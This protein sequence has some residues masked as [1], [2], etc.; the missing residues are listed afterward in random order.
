MKQSITLIVPFYNAQQTILLCL[1]SIF[2][3]L[4][5]PDQ[6]ILVDNVSTDNT[7]SR[8][9]KFIKEKNAAKKILILSERKKGPAAARN[10]ALSYAQTDL[11][12]F[13]DADCILSNNWIEKILNHYE[14]NSKLRIIT[15]KT[16][17]YLPGNIIGK[18]MALEWYWIDRKRKKIC[19]KESKISLK[20]CALFR[21]SAYKAEVFDEVGMLDERF[22]FAGEDTDFRVRLMKKN[23]DI[24]FDSELKVF[25]K[26]RSRL[27]QIL[28]QI[29]LY[30]LA[31][32]MIIKKHFPNTLIIEAPFLD[33]VSFENSPITGWVKISFLY[34]LIL[35]MAIFVCFTQ[36][37]FI[38]AVIPVYIYVKIH[39]SLKKTDIET[40]FVERIVIVVL[41]LLRRMLFVLG[42]LD[43]SIKNR[44]ICC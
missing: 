33:R 24:F 21:N 4:M 37:Y 16:Y 7:V 19:S 2:N 22:S 35:G 11:I 44:V 8:I 6:I 34:I 26:D 15:G 14:V 30:G 28:K 10:K 31:H 40:S 38:L 43:G 12:A 36:N 41:F 42:K 13:A 27:K 9:N 5:L 39:N 18:F 1:E 3:Q 29:F 23:I 20:D 32:P 25:H 17:G